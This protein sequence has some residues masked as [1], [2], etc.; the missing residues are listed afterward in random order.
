MIGHLK[1]AIVVCLALLAVATFGV[2]KAQAACVNPAGNE[3]DI[4]YNSTHK[5]MQFC[6]NADEWIAMAGSSGGGGGSTGVCPN[7]E[8]EYLPSVDNVYAGGI[9]Q[10]GA[11]VFYTQDSNSGTSRIFADNATTGARITSY[12][13]G[14]RSA[15]V[16]SIWGDGTYVYVGAGTY[17]YGLSF[18]GTTF[19]AVALNTSQGVYD[20][21]G[22]GTYIYI[23]NGTTGIRAYTFNGTT[24]TQIGSTYN[25]PGTASD[26][27]SDGTYIYS[28]DDGANLRAFS[29][30]G[31]SFTVLD[32]QA[33]NYN[34]LAGDGTYIYVANFYGSSDVYT[35][36]GSSFTD[37]GVQLERVHAASNGY[38][39]S[40]RGVSPIVHAF[41]GTTATYGAAYTND[42]NTL[43]DINVGD[44]GNVYAISDYGAVVYF[45]DCSI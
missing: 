14:T 9:W 21:W 19:S 12:S 33:G 5:M 26:I 24:F 10:Q 30:N 31:T 11:Y 34:V 13:F 18:N 38:V 7:V 22:D 44:N 42:G 20:I 41:D 39:Y 35:F 17:L 16:G 3:G 1:F 32:T 15:R 23:A 36:D 6:N 4:V 25:T 43:Y 2:Q 27:W 29:F 37:L 45:P 40:A 28:L 8:T